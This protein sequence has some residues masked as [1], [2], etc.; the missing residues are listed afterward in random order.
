MAKYKYTQSQGGAA[1]SG[2]NLGVIGGWTLA[3]AMI[4][5]IASYVAY[6]AYEMWSGTPIWEAATLG[7]LGECE[8]CKGKKKAKSSEGGG[9]QAS[10]DGGGPTSRVAAAQA[11]IAQ[12][13]Y[14]AEA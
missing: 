12:R 7:L 5:A 13:R 11:A 9:L 1:K 8:S 10:G 6:V 14:A 2:P 4:V 3:I